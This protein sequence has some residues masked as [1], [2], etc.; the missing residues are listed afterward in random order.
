[1][2]FVFLSETVLP[3]IWSLGYFIMSRIAWTDSCLFLKQV[4]PVVFF[5]SSRQWVRFMDVKSGNKADRVVP[6]HAAPV[7]LCCHS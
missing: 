7:A 5:D 1:M 2:L 4:L 6:S 3:G